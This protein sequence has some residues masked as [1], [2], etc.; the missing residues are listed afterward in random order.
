M[1][2]YLLF[3]KKF[4]FE[5]PFEEPVKLR[6]IFGHSFEE[7]ME[8]LCALSEVSWGSLSVY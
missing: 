7:L 2:I 8:V 6:I 3:D 4:P 1:F 5:G